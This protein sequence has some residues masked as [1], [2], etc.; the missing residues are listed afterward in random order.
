MWFLVRKD[1]ERAMAEVNGKV[2]KKT[3]GKEGEGRQVAVDWALSKEKWQEA[4]KKDV[5]EEVQEE[6]S[7]SSESDERSSS[8]STGSGDDSTHE[9]GGAMSVDKEERVDESEPVK[10]HLPSVDVGS[11]LFIRNLPFETTEQEL[12]TLYV[13]NHWSGCADPYHASFRTFG[14]LRYA[15]ITIDKLTG[16]SKGSGFVCFWNTPHADAAIAEA[17]RVVQETGANAMPV[18]LPQHSAKVLTG[19]ARRKESVRSAVGAHS[20]PVFGPGEQACTAWQDP[21]RVSCCD[22]RACWADERGW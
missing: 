10:P 3:G 19:V 2:I 14:P 13:N 12:N 5:G 18:G 8:V 20:G 4:Q 16:R 9:E 1:A 17:E 21:R 11:T 6:G 7:G 15:R 22:E